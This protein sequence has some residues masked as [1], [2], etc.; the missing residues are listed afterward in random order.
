MP[1]SHLSP[2]TGSVIASDHTNRE[3]GDHA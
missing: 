1:L 2:R 3:F